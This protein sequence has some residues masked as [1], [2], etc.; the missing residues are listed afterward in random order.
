MS[1][2]LQRQP[3]QLPAMAVLSMAMLLPSLGTSIANVALPTLAEHFGVSMA[4]AQWVVVAYLLAVTSF[5]VAA[6]RLGDQFGRTPILTA[7]IALFALASAA[8][9]LSPSLPFLIAARVAQGAG[10]A[11]LMSLTIAMV[12]D[13]VPQDKTGVAIGWLGTVSAV[14]TALGPTLGGMLI[15]NAGWQTI[16]VLLAVLGGITWLLLRMF[17]SAATPSRKV[18]SHDPVG[19]VLLAISLA[20]LCAA[21]TMW[22]RTAPASAFAL[23]G[24]GMIGLAAFAA[25]ELRI[26]APLVRLQ[27]VK[28]GQVASGL[29]GMM[30]V[31]VVVMTTL[32]VGPFYLTHELHLSPSNTGLVMSVGP[33][34]AALTGVPAGKLVD[35]A[36]SGLMQLGGLLAALG[37]SAMMMFLP[38]RLGVPGYVASLAVITLGYA[39]FQ[40][41]NTTRLMQEVDKGDRGVM[42]ALLGLARNLGLIVGASIMGAVYAVQSSLIMTFALGGGLIGVCVVVTFLGDPMANSN[43]S[44]SNAKESN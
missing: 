8:A 14:G 41:A 31:S 19:M 36:G 32:V 11:V 6:G 43:G 7:G 44:R 15:S 5:I 30:T 18:T 24:G 9:A 13:M 21:A 12:S 22:N 26:K 23:A 33:V 25:Y 3:G 42:S 2:P 39:V 34:V 4:G 37:G 16:F 20:A 28:Q 35:A 1:R 27:M 38:Q 29:L 17:A 10:A 40:A